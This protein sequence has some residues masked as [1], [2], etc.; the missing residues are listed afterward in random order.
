ML[1]NKK[2]MDGI[3]GCWTPVKW[4]PVTVQRLPSAVAWRGSEWIA[5]TWAKSGG[6][7]EG[8]FFAPL[9][10]AK[11]R[12]WQVLCNIPRKNGQLADGYGFLWWTPGWLNKK[13]SPFGLQLADLHDCWWRW[14]R[15]GEAM[16]KAELVSFGLYE[17]KKSCPMRLFSGLV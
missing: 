1:R 11:L 8:P 15:N 7:W 6:S 12:L 3:W 17:G 4:L 13:R 16:K 2:V 5:S 14:R 10:P 9:H